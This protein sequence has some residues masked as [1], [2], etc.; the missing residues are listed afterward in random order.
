MKILILGSEG[1]RGAISI[2]RGLEDL[3]VNI[4][5]AISKSKKY[6]RLAY[7][8]YSKT[9]LYYEDSYFENFINSLIKFANIIGGY[10]IYCLGDEKTEWLIKGKKELN[11]N[12]IVF[13]AP[14]YESFLMMVN[15]PRFLKVASS[16]GLSIPGEISVEEGINLLKHKESIVLKAKDKNTLKKFKAPIIINK[17]KVLKQIDFEKYNFIIQNFI[18]GPSVYYSAYYRNGKK[19]AFFEQINLVQQP[20]GGSVLKAAPYKIDPSVIAKTDEM[21][22]SLD[23]SGVMMVEFKLCK[24]Y[25]YVIECNP[26]FWGPNQLALDNGINYASLMLDKKNYVQ[27]KKNNP[28]GYKWINGYIFGFISWIRGRGKFQKYSVKFQTKVRYYDLWNRKDTRLY[29]YF[30]VLLKTLILKINKKFR[31]KS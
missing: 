14:G 7:K 27:R 9:I 13:E 12:K 1:D 20:C 24:G 17:L 31:R 30:E 10:Y 25:Y 4:F 6:E 16:F 23:W 26:R 15:K 22:K 3:N 21:F 2:I 19:I 28:I 11:I 29:F 18:F 5:V 8:K